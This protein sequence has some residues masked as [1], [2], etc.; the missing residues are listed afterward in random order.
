MKENLKKKFLDKRYL[1]I[2][3]GLLL[4]YVSMDDL[5]SV[6]YYSHYESI[7]FSTS[8]NNCENC[9][10]VGIFESAIQIIIGYI[11][12]VYN[13]YCEKLPYYEKIKELKKTLKENQEE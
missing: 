2:L 10:D 1:F 13:S 7:V 3:I 12:I 9:D 11:M 8:Y 6:F 4:I 5:V